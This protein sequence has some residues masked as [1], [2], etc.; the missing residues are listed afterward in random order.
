MIKVRK[1]TV[2]MVIR[3]TLLV[4]LVLLLFLLGSV[5]ALGYTLANGPSETLRNM[6][7]LSAKQASATK[8]LPSLFLDRETIEQILAD[9]VEVTVTEIDIND[10][11]PKEP[12]TDTSEPGVY[13]EWADWP[14]EVRIEFLNGATFK[15]YLMIVKDP[16]RVFTGVANNLGTAAYGMRVYAMAEKYDALALINGGEF[17]D[18]GKGPGNQPIGLTY[19]QGKC[20]WNDGKLRTFIGF[21]NN[22]RLVVREGL[23]KEEAEQLGIRDGCCFQ[24]GNVL[25]TND[26]DKIQLHY[27]DANTGTAQRTAIGQRAD[28]T[29]LMLVPAG[30]TASSIGATRNDII[31]LMVSYGAVTAGMLD[32]GS[33]AMMY[34]ENYIDIYADIYNID[35]NALDQYQLKGLVNKYQAFTPPRTMPT[36]FVVSKRTEG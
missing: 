25:I 31:D 20:V 7:V 8:W 18:N 19:S 27:S 35:R 6:L 24:T 22:N 12:D 34:Y 36:Y 10:Y 4:L 14:E 32:G 1:K 28:G 23:T 17:P 21:D 5:Y 13:D 2:F 11:R 29:V 9:S 3:R 33:S 26:G 15:A 30:R 16:S